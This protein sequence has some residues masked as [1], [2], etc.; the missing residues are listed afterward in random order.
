MSAWRYDSSILYKRTWLTGV[1]EKI[2]ATVGEVIM[3]GHPFDALGKSTNK[4]KPPRAKETM[5]VSF[6]DS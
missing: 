4:S 1:Q 2:W 3:P 5:C 6:G